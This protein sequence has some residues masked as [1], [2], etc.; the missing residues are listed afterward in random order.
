MVNQKQI[1]KRHKRTGK[2]KIQMDGTSYEDTITEIWI[3]FLKV[4]MKTLIRV[5]FSIYMP[6]NSNVSA[7]DLFPPI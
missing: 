2:N 1:K 4:D 6:S 5:G 7:S 3:C